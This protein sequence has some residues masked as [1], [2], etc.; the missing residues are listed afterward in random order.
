[1]DRV[2]PASRMLDIWSLSLERH[3]CDFRWKLKINEEFFELYVQSDM[4]L[5]GVLRDKLKPMPFVRFA[6]ED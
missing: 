4:P 6:S 1:M 2:A 5:L 3:Y